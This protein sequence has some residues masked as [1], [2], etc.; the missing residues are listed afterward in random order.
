MRLVDV[1]E[2]FFHEMQL[3]G[4]TQTWFCKGGVQPGGLRTEYVKGI[5]IIVPPTM[6]GGG[7]L[8]KSVTRLAYWFFETVYLL[9]QLRSPP[10]A[11]LIRDKYWAA[12]VAYFVARACGCKFLIW[13]SYPYPEHDTE[14]AQTATGWRRQLKKARASL[15]RRL[16]YR[17]AMP[18]ADHCFVQSE[19]MKTDLQA[20]GI[21]PE[22]MTAVP[23][24]IARRV[25]DS[26]DL[27][28]PL[29]SP[30]TVLYLGTLAGVRKLD[31]LVDTFAIVARKRPDIR[32]QFVG[33]GD[34]PAERQQLEAH[35]H[36]RGLSEVVEFTGQLPMEEAWKHVAAATVC[37]SPFRVTPVLRVASPTKFVEYLAFAKATVGNKHPEH[38][39]IAQASDGALT[40]DWSPEAFAEAILWCLDHPG[41]ARE[42]ALRGRAW[43][44]D[45][46]TYDK[47]GDLVYRRLT[48]IIRAKDGVGG[49]GS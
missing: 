39:A 47:L 29:T 17:F 7:L 8:A 26:V 11:I 42:M 36:R 37:L 9:K 1:T 27:T 48:S 33:D 43:V 6:S 23:M 14:E 18:R 38:S 21:A 49:E 4:V 41:E 13:L 5:Q 46:R 34:V 45:N 2:L 20:W 25:F 40:V 35:V 32:F 15:G 24:G 22:K 12:M 44:Q 10:D 3:R 28:T 31:I 30:P 19:Q 16:L